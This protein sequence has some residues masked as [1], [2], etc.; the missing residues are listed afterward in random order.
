[1]LNIAPLLHNIDMLVLLLLQS[2]MV[3]DLSFAPS[4]MTVGD[5]YIAAGGTS[6]QVSALLLQAPTAHACG[7]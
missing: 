6:S 4:S 7:W 2:S 5:G 1:M 3:Q